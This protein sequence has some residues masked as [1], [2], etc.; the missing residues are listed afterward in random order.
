MLL[1]Y[2]SSRSRECRCILPRQYY[3]CVNGSV[4]ITSIWA[5]MS[6]WSVGWSVKAGLH[7]TILLLLWN[8]CS[9]GT[10]KHTGQNGRTF[11][12][13][14]F[15]SP[16]WEQFPLSIWMIDM[17]LNSLS[18]YRFSEHLFLGKA[19]YNSSSTE[20]M[21]ATLSENIAIFCSH[22]YFHLFAINTK[23]WFS[24]AKTCVIY[25]CTILFFSPKVTLVFFHMCIVHI[26]S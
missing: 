2:I 9:L 3:N 18:T 10:T 14:R 5:L 26:H 22:R 7:Y 19:K 8:K 13:R 20:I 16:F 24:N 21:C 11:L 1:L 15:L 17:T 12:A 25:I 6:D 4:Y 23:L